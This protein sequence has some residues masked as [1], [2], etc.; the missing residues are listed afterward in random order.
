MQE[1][2]EDSSAP[3]MEVVCENKM[4]SLQRVIREMNAFIKSHDIAP[5]L[6]YAI[7]LATEELGTNIIEHGYEDQDTHRIGITLDLSRPATLTL[8]D[9]GKKFNPLTDAPAVDL[10]DA[11]EERP[12]GGLG[13]RMIQ[14][15]G[16]PLKYRRENDRNILQV[17]FPAS[18]IDSPRENPYAPVHDYS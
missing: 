5:R 16:M 13:L 7:R 10:D 14:S 6:A 4:E 8:V 1:N 17:I 3:K 2:P 11:I 15:M 9:D 12:I 18:T